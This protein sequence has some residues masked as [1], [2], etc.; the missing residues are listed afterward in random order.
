MHSRGI[1]I[2]SKLS[3]IKRESNYGE[4]DLRTAEGDESSENRRHA[5]D[6]RAGRDQGNGSR[7]R[8][9]VVENKVT[10]FQRAEGGIGLLPREKLS[11]VSFR[12][13]PLLS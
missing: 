11:E 9:E 10:G 8:G 4:D 2:H 7:E 3:I 6:L 12:R 5:M 1:T 13:R